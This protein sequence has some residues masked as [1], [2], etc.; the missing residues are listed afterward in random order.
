MRGFLDRSR[1]LQHV[2]QNVCQKNKKLRYCNPESPPLATGRH[3]KRGKKDEPRRS[4]R[5]SAEPMGQTVFTSFGRSRII[6]M[7]APGLRALYGKST[8]PRL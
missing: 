4:N 2:P 1:D 3:G 5:R 8:S 7:A 6:R